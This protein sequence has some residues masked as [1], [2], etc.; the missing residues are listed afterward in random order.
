MWAISPRGLC[1]NH[2]L[3]EHMEMHKIVGS[4]EHGHLGLVISLADKGYIDTRLLFV[5]HTLLAE[6]MTRRG[7]RHQS[8]LIVPRDMIERGEVDPLR[9][10]HDLFARCEKCRELAQAIPVP[11][12]TSHAMVMGFYAALVYLSADRMK[13]A[14]V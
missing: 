9:S 6:E 7:Y 5:R 3:G 12:A 4:W 10:N 1:R 11:I 8:P 13:E 14:I 2:L